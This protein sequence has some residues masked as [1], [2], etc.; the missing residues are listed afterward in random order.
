M[1]RLHQ[2]PVLNKLLVAI[3]AAYAQTELSAT[4]NAA[5]SALGCS[6]LTAPNQKPIFFAPTS[7]QVLND[8]LM[9]TIAVQ[10]DRSAIATATAA[11]L[12]ASL[13]AVQSATTQAGRNTA[14]IYE[15]LGLSTVNRLV[16][17]DW[18]AEPGRMYTL[19]PET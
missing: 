2:V 13:L 6:R 9:A 5:S 11:L 7:K 18:L 15:G 19:T 10:A 4:A 12:Q 14:A 17:V 16:V 8:L 1:A 3:I